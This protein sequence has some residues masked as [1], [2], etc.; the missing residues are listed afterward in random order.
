MAAEARHFNAGCLPSY[1]QLLSCSCFFIHVGL[2]NSL[3]QAYAAGLVKRAM[4]EQT[5]HTLKT[6]HRMPATCNR[7]PSLCTICVRV[8]TQ[9]PAFRVS[10]RHNYMLNPLAACVSRNLCKA[11]CGPAERSQPFCCR[12]RSVQYFWSSRVHPRHLRQ[13]NVQDGSKSTPTCARP[14]ADPLIPCRPSRCAVK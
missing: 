2:V 12:C 4:Q 7:T 13:S 14:N 6:Q 9:I 3:S 8:H 1:Q 11:S 5:R 10:G